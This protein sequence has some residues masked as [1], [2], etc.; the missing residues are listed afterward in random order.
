MLLSA[1]VI[2]GLEGY[3]IGLIDHVS[4]PGRVLDESIAYAHELSRLCSPAAMAMIKRQVREDAAADFEAVCE[5][6][7]DYLR[8]AVEWPDLEEGVRSFTEGRP[9]RFRSLS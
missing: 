6:A 8:V 9:P 1:R 3:A 4:T 2:S 5:R 7:N